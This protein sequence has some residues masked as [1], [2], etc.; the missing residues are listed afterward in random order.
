MFVCGTAAILTP[1]GKLTYKDS[2]IE[3]AK[4]VGEISLEIRQKI[5][6]IQV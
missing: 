3:A 1:V 5:E 6:D 2:V 4:P